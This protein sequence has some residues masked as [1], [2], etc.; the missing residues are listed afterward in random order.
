MGKTLKPAAPNRSQYCI[1]PELLKMRAADLPGMT[2]LTIRELIPSIPKPIFPSENGVE[3]IRQAIRDSLDGVDMTKIKPGDSVN[4]LASHHGFTLY[5]GIAYAE[6]IKVTRD[7]IT[8]RT[9]GCAPVWGCDSG[10]QRSTSRNSALI[11][12]STGRPWG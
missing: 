4:I 7:V 1:D 6:L 3:G 10:R 5:G 9:Y 11:S 12:I 8:E 2:S